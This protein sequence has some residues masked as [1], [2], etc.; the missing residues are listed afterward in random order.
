MQLA[1]DFRHYCGEVR[2]SK[3]VLELSTLHGVAKEIVAVELG[4]QSP[5]PLDEINGLL[6]QLVQDMG[7]ALA[8]LMDAEHVVQRAC[9]SFDR[10]FDRGAHTLLSRSIV[11]YTAPWTARVAELHARAAVDVGAEK[12]VARLTDELRV[13][14][15]DL[16]VKVRS[17]SLPLREDPPLMMRPCFTQDQ[18]CQEGLV[19]IEL[20]EKR[21]EAVKKQ[22]EVMAQL[23]A[24]LAKS[25]KQERTYEEANEVLQRDLDS[26]ER[27]LH[28]LKQ[29]VPGPNADVPGKCWLGRLRVPDSS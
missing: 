7:T 28:Q 6:A 2:A 14:T 23:E 9:L 21:L 13:V 10:A 5:R 20:M 25:R 19:K 16:R 12:D 3:E 8:T 22:A 29:S 24:D 11:S 26:M 4:K 18:E 27:E 1:G 15:Q 17:V